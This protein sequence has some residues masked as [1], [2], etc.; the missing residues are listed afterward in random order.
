MAT[1]KNESLVSVPIK[2]ERIVLFMNL[3]YIVCFLTSNQIKITWFRLIRVPNNETNP[4][5]FWIIFLSGIICLSLFTIMNPPWTFLPF[6]VLEKM[7]QMVLKKINTGREEMETR[8]GSRFEMEREPLHQRTPWSFCQPSLTVSTFG[9][10]LLQACPCP[11][12]QLNRTSGLTV[13]WATVIPPKLFLPS[14][15][16]SRLR[17]KFTP[18]K[19]IEFDGLYNPKQWR[20]IFRPVAKS[21]S[22]VQN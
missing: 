14:K 8:S 13:G 16:I 19:E 4:E 2:L 9:P 21:L 22:D 17:L 6:Q 15:L 20:L 3:I 12:C 5:S 18:I 11:P 7:T 1:L 10:C